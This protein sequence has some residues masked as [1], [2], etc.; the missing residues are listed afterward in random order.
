MRTYSGSEIAAMDEAR[1]QDSSVFEV[2]LFLLGVLCG[3]L[4]TLLVRMPI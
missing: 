2:T 1:Q 3:V 4:A